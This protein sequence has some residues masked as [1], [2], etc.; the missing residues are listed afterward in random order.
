MFTS[1]SLQIYSCIQLYMDVSASHFKGIDNDKQLQY[2]PMV[3]M[4]KNMCAHSAMTM[5]CKMF[6]ASMFSSL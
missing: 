5:T 4:F 1:V 2:M 6:L 3:H